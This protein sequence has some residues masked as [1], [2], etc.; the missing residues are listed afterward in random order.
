VKDLSTDSRVGEA[1]RRLALEKAPNTVSQLV[2]WRLVTNSEWERIAAVARPWANPHELTLARQFISA[3]D[4]PAPRSP[5][6]ADPGTFYWVVSGDDETADPVLTKLRDVLDGRL[7]LGLKTK[8][9]IPARPTS[10]GLACEAHLTGSGTDAMLDVRLAV[11]DAECVR[12]VSSGRFSLPIHDASKKLLEPSKIVDGLAAQV[13]EHVVRAKLAHGPRV[14]GKP[15]Y[16]ITIRN[17][18]PLVLNGLALS[19]A[20]ADEVSPEI[21]VLWGI[22]IPP[23]RDYR[24]PASAQVVERLRLRKGIRVVGADLSG[25]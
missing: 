15:T 8:N 1:L 20:L 25:L 10:P 5:V 11:T 22:C 23:H 2:I 14:K 19:G 6:E 3:L 24:V 13:L 4:E 18:S 9:E 21:S 16:S 12:W 17:A 7:L